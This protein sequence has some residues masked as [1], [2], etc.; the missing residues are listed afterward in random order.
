[1][2]RWHCLQIVQFGTLDFFKQHRCDNRLT[3]LCLKRESCDEV[4]L[5]REK[6]NG[7]ALV[8]AREIDHD[9]L[10]SELMDLFWV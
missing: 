6:M 3:A 1:M 5:R 8:A 4:G 7:R 2:V 10:L 9:M